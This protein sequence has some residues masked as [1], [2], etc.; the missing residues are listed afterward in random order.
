MSYLARD[1]MSVF[2]TSLTT[3][4]VLNTALLVPLR[5]MS[6]EGFIFRSSAGGRSPGRWSVEPV[7]SL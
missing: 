5:T 4:F 3:K 6:E 2:I 1:F 7:R